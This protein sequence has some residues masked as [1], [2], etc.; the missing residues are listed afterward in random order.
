[1]QG[2]TAPAQSAA[3]ATTASHPPGDPFVRTT[4]SSQAKLADGSGATE[5]HGL[6]LL[7]VTRH[8][9]RACR[10][11]EAMRFIRTKRSAAHS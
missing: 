7:D 11:N 4:S 9:V 3:A 5:A 2:E 8:A 10:T 1:M 6:T